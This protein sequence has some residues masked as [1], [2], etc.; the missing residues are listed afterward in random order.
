MKAVAVGVVGIAVMTVVL[1]SFFWWLR[2]RDLV[3]HFIA[4]HDF[5]GWVDVF[6]L[7]GRVFGPELIGRA[8]RCYRALAGGVPV[9]LVVEEVPVGQR[10]RH[11]WLLAARAPRGT[12]FAVT[13]QGVDGTVPA[14]LAEMMAAVRQDKRIDAVL[15]GH[16]LFVVRLVTARGLEPGLALLRQCLQAP[17]GGR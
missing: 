1:V 9:E 13:A 10:H 17:G 6:R 8:R 14:S 11:R 7:E 16:G 3:H 5:V 2:R 15:A 12:E 4:D